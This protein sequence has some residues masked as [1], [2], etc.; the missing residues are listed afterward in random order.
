MSVT[1]EYLKFLLE[2]EDVGAEAG[3]GEFKSL[4]VI[5]KEKTHPEEAGEEN[6]YMQ[7]EEL[8]VDEYNEGDDDAEYIETDGPEL[9]GYDDDSFDD[10]DLDD[11]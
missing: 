1:N 6:D 5:G 10:L 2:S 9:D 3:T 4:K 11:K 7:G 8:E